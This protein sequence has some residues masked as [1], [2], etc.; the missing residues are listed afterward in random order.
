M[1]L[2]L[3]AWDLALCLGHIFSSPFF[4][5]KGLPQPGCGQVLILHSLHIPILFSDLSWIPQ[6][7]QLPFVVSF[8]I[9]SPSTID[10]FLSDLC[11]CL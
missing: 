8:S 10:D 5:Q 1:V 4:S 2:D 7:L 3:L 9:A 6:V 11:L